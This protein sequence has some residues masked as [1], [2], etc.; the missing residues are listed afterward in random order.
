MKQILFVCTANICRS[1]VVA[2]LAAQ[3]FDAAGLGDEVLV[4]SAGVYAQ[5][6]KP[7]WEP[8]RLLMAARGVDLQR[9]RS[10]PVSLDILQS[11]ALIVVMEEAHRQSLFYLE[12]R[13]LRKVLL[14]SELAG[15]FGEL[16]D[17]MGRP[18]PEVEQIC[19]QAEQWLEAGWDQILERLA[20]TPAM[21]SKAD[22][23]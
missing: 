1:P 4:R 16:H 13:V 14:L 20:I 6:G 18:V 9:H 10:Q 21:T 11:A 3:R 12:P 15:E 23:I 22:P 8:L 2:A 5:P 19:R 7:V 17:M